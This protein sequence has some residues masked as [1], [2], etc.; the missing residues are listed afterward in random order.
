MSSSDKLNAEKHARDSLEKQFDGAM[1]GI[2][3]AIEA[4]EPRADNSKPATPKSTEWGEADVIVLATFGLTAV[5]FTQ[6][7]NAHATLANNKMGGDAA[8]QISIN[9]TSMH[10]LKMYFTKFREV[11]RGRSL[12][13]GEVTSC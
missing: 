13:R 3:K 8:V 2:G 5:L 10:R 12:A 9:R 6:G 11:R 7:I 4:S 1:G